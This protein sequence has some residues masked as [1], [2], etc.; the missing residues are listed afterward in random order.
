MFVSIILTIILTLLI[1][2]H[3][4]NNKSAD[5]VYDQINRQVYVFWTGNNPLTGKRKKC[6]ESIKKNIG[7]PVTLITP[8]NLDEYILSHSPIH[9][10]YKY[11]SGTH[12]SDYLRTCL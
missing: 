8:D 12:K 5:F 3:V 11:L 4:S 6:L 2:E 9:K 1:L 10:S 7:V